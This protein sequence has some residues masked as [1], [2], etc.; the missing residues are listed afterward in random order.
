MSAP[1]RLTSSQRD[2]ALGRLRAITVGTAV[3]ASAAVGAF[4][5]LAIQTNPGTQAAG[6]STDRAAV[7][8]GA[9]QTPA[10]TD[11]VTGAD[12]RGGAGIAAPTTAPTRTP[13]ATRTRHATSGG[14]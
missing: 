5:F 9:T 13:A 1:S 3:A 14:S 6:D 10:A 7:D 4:G 11:T 2:R 8:V 12:T